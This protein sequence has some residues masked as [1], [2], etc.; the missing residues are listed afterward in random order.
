MIVAIPTMGMIHC[1]TRYNCPY[2]SHQN[3]QSPSNDVIK[4][5]KIR[6]IFEIYFWD[7]LYYPIFVLFFC[8]LNLFIYASIDK[9]NLMLDLFFDIWI[10]IYC[11]VNTEYIPKIGLFFLDGVV[12]K[13]SMGAVVCFFPIFLSSN[14]FIWKI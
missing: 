10:S 14:F 9:G 11:L 4:T 2:R 1:A 7:I 12:E 3:W 6:D 8:A 5:E 13:I